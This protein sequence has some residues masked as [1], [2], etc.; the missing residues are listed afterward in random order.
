VFLKMKTGPKGA[1]DVNAEPVK[2]AK[3]GERLT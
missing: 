2:H 3:S 1:P